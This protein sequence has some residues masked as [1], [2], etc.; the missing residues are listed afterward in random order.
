[1]FYRCKDRHD[2]VRWSWHD[3]R[4]CWFCR[5]EGVPSYALIVTPLDDNDHVPVTDAV[6]VGDHGPEILR[7]PPNSHVT[8]MAQ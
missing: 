6:M 7:M 8:R 3:G 1:M 5:A 4:Y 2:E